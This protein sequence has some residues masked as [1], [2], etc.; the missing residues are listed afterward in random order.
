M[1][2]FAKVRRWQPEPLDQAEHQLKGRSEKLLGLADEFA[3][4]GTPA[5]WAGDAAEFARRR[6]TRVSDRME[7]IVAGVAAARSALRNAADAIV[8]LKH[9]VAE[10]DG[11]AAS[12]GFAIDADGAIRDV[13]PPSDVPAEHADDVSRERARIQ[14]EL[15]DRVEQIMRRAADIDNDLATVLG[16]V[17]NGEIGDDG[18]TDLASAATAGAGQGDLSVLEPPSGRGTPGDNAGWWDT[19]SKAEQR[20]IINE[21][22]EWIGNR[23]GVPYTARDHANRALLGTERARLQEEARRLEADLDDNMFGGLFTNDDARLDQVREKLEAIRTIEG[24]LAKPGERQLLLLDLTNERAEAAISNG[25]VDTADHVAVFTPGLT[26]NVP[27]SMQ[28]YDGNMDQLQFRTEEELRRYG[29]D[30]SVATVT[31]IGY[32]APQWSETIIDENSVTED[33]AARKGAEKLA[34]FL[35]GIDTARDTDAHLTALGHS[36]G[37]TTTGLALQQN[38]GVDDAVFF[39]SPG[40]GT[41]HLNEINVPDGHAT[42]IE[43]KWDG[44]GDLGHF[45]I[46]PSHLDGMQHGSSAEAQ[47]PADS[48]RT[49]AGVTGHSA[50]LRDGS[51]SQYNMSVT[52]GGMSDKMVSGNDRGVTDVLSWPIPGT[53]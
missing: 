49:L 5:C 21:N 50:Y 20:R 11:L 14:A 45:G 46:D 51:T 17:A 39:G 53:Y 40:L 10:A 29:E 41:D 24:T 1:V 30:P 27:D 18:A 25:N 44:V 12:Q 8:G 33:H 26:S 3:A 35:Q 47:H 23:D 38:T 32:Q 4:M 19:L 22:P 28:G 7:H 43:A 36:Y 2:D 48:G 37:S 52:I 31:W 34:P 6:R 16:R 15:S 13:A 42:Y 9:G